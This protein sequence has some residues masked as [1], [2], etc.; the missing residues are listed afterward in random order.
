MPDE[1]VTP[2]TQ[3]WSGVGSQQQNG[4]VIVGLTLATG[5]KL[6]IGLAPEQAEQLAQMIL[7]NAKEARMKSS[8]LFPVFTRGV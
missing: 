6:A 2:A 3:A 7:S 8:P 5:E 1:I 4:L